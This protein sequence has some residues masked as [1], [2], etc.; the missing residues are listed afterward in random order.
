MESKDSGLFVVSTPIGNLKDITFRAIEVLKNSEFILAENPSKSIRLLQHYEIKTP[1]RSVPRV[2][3]DT[4]CKW[5]VEILRDEK[6]VSLISD[7]GTPGISDPGSGLVRFIRNLGLLIV[8]VPGPSALSAILSISGFQA[9]PTI[10]LGFLSEKKGKKERE[11]EKYRD[12]EGEIVFF[13]SVHRIAHTLELIKSLFPDSGILIG[14]ELT[15]L[16]EEIRLLPAGKD[17]N[18]ENIVKKGEFVILI[19]N[20]TKKILKTY[21]D[22]PIN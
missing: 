5:I 17:I 20:H 10:F 7:A 9:T 2:V 18:P 16:H 11:L 6:S 12:F 19:N 1:I 4:T 8:P 14:R 13:E 15:K 22:R 3:S 21:S